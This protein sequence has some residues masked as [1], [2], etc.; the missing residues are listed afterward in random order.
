MA[1]GINRFARCAVLCLAFL[2]CQGIRAAEKAQPAKVPVIAPLILQTLPHDERLFT[3]GLLF[4]NGLLD[5]SSGL[6]GKSLIRVYEPG[7]DDHAVNEINVPDVFAEGIALRGNRLIV[8]TWKEESALI[9]SV[10]ALNFKGT[11]SYKGEGWGLTTD[12]AGRFYMSNGSDTI[13]VRD[14]TFAVIRKVAVTLEGKP[15]RNLNELEFVAGR[16]YANIWYDSRIAEIKAATGTV[17]RLINCQDLVRQESPLS[18][19]N[20]LNGIAYNPSTGTF[21]LTGKRWRKMFEVKIR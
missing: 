13:F 18:G 5:E 12:E 16:I 2:F 20:V 17:L 8:L 11:F 6:Y 7:G 21:Y 9:Y 4:A 15:L 3:Q 14:S 10:P 1:Q 19:E